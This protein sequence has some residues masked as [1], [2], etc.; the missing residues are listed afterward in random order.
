MIRYQLS[1]CA[2]YN[3]DHFAIIGDA[4]WLL[5]SYSLTLCISPVVENVSL[6]HNVNA[7][8]MSRLSYIILY[9]ESRGP[10]CSEELMK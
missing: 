1:D 3:G 8:I 9:L 10:K 2:N 5:Y 4:Q 6:F 7:I